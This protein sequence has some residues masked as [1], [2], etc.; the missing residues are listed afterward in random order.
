M[1]I[2]SH[3]EELASA[4][5]VDKEEVKRDLENLV[6]YSVPL[7][8]AKQSLRRKYG[9]TGEDEATPVDIEDISVDD[10]S[11]L[12]TAKVLTVGRRS[13]RYQGE[14]QVIHE[15]EVA[16]ETGRVRYTAWEGIEFS[17]GDTVR[18]ANAGVREFGGEPE[19]NL[20]GNTVV[21]IEAEDIAVPFSVGGE[22]TLAEVSI[23]DRAK[24]IEIRVLEVDE[25]TID[26]R[27][28][29]TEI[30][31]GVIG[32]S[33][34]RLPF[35]DWDPR[36]AVSE[37]ADLRLQNV[38]VREFRGVPA[39]NLSSYTTVEELDEPVEV[40]PSGTRMDIRSA[41]KT[42]GV[43]DVELS[44]SIV[45]VRDGSGLIERCPQ[46]NRVLQ[47]GECRSHGAVDGEQ[48]LRTK[49]ILDDGMGT[50]TVILDADLTEAIYGG[51]VSE[52]REAA[53]D[54]MDRSV[55][56]DEI[57]SY[58]LGRSYRVR[59]H[60]S[61][62]DYGANLEATEFELLETDPTDEATTLLAEVADE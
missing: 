47:N 49:A 13:I 58:L 44:G 38:Y 62:D 53:R 34:G 18:I 30:L 11:V 15:G 36:P 7:D 35:T 25:R 61:V 22:T 54:A 2:E 26:G 50:V 42:G 60:L 14:E 39:V 27:D 1:E 29:E 12:I 45:A 41:V 48:D 55:V 31:D 20:G 10:G 4:L 43:Y 46:C 9:G 6:N 32:D 23:G 5:G 21:T 28:G 8:E 33:S 52:A 51:N 40:A 19:L 59:G 24:V 17:P 16:D 37:G 3:A 57:R 56:A